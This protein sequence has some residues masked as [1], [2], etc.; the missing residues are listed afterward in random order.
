MDAAALGVV[1]PARWDDF[2]ALRAE[3]D[4]NNIFLTD[5]WRDRLGLW[6][7][8]RPKPTYA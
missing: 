1:A 6:D 5:Y 8:P 4:P 2:L 3:R 7:L